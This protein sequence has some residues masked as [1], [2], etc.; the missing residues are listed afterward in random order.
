[1][2]STGDSQHRGQGCNALKDVLFLGSHS[3]HLHAMVAMLVSAMAL[4]TAASRESPAV[5]SNLVVPK[6]STGRA[7]ITGEADVLSYNGSLYFFFNDWGVRQLRHHFG[8]SLRDIRALHYPLRA[9]RCALLGGCA[10]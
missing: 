2:I 8:P 5:L 6:D 1:M 9:V 7:L 3:Y 4:A 10:Y